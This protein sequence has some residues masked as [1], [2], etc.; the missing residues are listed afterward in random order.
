VRTNFFSV[1]AVEESNVISVN[2]EM[3]RTVGVQESVQKLQREPTLA[4]TETEA[5]VKK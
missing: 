4:V 5:R 3:V 2:I 1:R